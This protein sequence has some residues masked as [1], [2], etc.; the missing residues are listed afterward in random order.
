MIALVGL[1]ELSPRLRDQLMVTIRDRALIEAR[2]KGLD[3]AAALRHPFRQLLK[4]DI[5]VS[6]FAVSVMLLIYYTAVGFSVIYLTTVF[7]FSVKDA[8]GLG[9]WNWGFNV[10]AVLLVGIVSDRFRVR[11]PFM[12]VGG[13]IAAVMAVVYLEQAATTRAT[14]RSRSCWRW[15]RSSWAWHTRPWMASF[16][17]TR[18]GKQPGAHRHRPGDLGLDPP[19]GGVR[20]LPDHPGHRQLGHPAGQLRVHRSAYADPATA[21]SWLRPG[22]PAVVATA[23]T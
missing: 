3:V 18:G 13:V 1:R 11:K 7:G 6:A 10:I 8:N 12:V 22:P 4:V 9:N 19:G 2:A 16:T 15:A 5:V 21:A 14:T 23:T 20:R 17:E